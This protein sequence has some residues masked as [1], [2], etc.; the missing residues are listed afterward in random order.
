ME[1]SLFLIMMK[2]WVVNEM[3]RTQLSP[4]RLSETKKTNIGRII[5]FCEGKTEKYY[6]GNCQWKCTDCFKL[7]K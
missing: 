2:L 4:K 6:F 3:G 5:I 7:C 1:R